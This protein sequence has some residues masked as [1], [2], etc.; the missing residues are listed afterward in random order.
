MLEFLERSWGLEIRGFGRPFHITKIN[1]TSILV[2]DMD[3]HSIIE[4]DLNKLSWRLN[5]GNG[6]WLSPD[7]STEILLN[8][9]EDLQIPK[10]CGPH[11]T[12]LDQDGNILIVCYYNRSLWTLAPCGSATKVLS[13]DILH[14][15]ASIAR[16][17]ENTL[18]IAD[19]GSSSIIWCDN[20]LKPNGRMGYSNGR[21]SFC[22]PL[23]A[24]CSA[25]ESAFSLDRVHMLAGYDDGSF[26][27]ADTWNNRLL[28]CENSISELL[29]RKPGLG[30]YEELLLTEHRNFAVPVS[31]DINREKEALVASWQNNAVILVDEK[32]KRFDLE[33]AVDLKKP[34]HAVF[35]EGG[36]IVADS[37]HSRVL[38]LRNPSFR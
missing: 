6:L 5:N 11:S 9:D 4:L 23:N 17:D 25:V 37:H 36:I 1:Q 33:C 20:E 22:H 27:I 31:V 26:L 16:I 38:F 21:F 29:R 19:Y 2:C 7:Q 24:K 15:P 30:D 10:F 32:F 12:L 14:G 35:A 3:Y 34:Y 18:A 8:F 28:F 13:S